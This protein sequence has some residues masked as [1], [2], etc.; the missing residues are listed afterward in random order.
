MIFLITSIAKNITTILAKVNHYISIAAH[1]LLFIYFRR[2]LMDMKKLSI[3]V[4]MTTSFIA[5]TQATEVVAA[6]NAGFTKLCVTAAAGNI[7]A[8]QNKIRASGYLGPFVAK[9]IQC[10]GEDLISFIKK[11]GKN[12]DA[13][14]YSLNR[15]RTKI[16]NTEYPNNDL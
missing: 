2:I 12:A 9:N 14:S 16:S 7:A 10:N 1:K 5:S 4:L 15:L 6:N 3:V 8:M 13:M 11:N